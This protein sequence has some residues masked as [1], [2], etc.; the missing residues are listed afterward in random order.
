LI[1]CNQCRR[2]LGFSCH[3]SLKK[4]LIKKKNSTQNL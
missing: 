1:R 3:F 2:H 4:F